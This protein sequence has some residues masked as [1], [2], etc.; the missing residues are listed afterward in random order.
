MPLTWVGLIKLKPGTGPQ[1]EKVIEEAFSEVS[2][3]DGVARKLAFMK[4]VEPDAHFDRL[5][6]KLK[7]GG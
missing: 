7:Q 2:E 3:S 4:M 6:R 1:F 5:I